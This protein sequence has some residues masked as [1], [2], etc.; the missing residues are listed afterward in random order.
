MTQTFKHEDRQVIRV[1]FGATSRWNRYMEFSDRYPRTP[2]LGAGLGLETGRK[3]EILLSVY[4]FRV[5]GGRIA[6]DLWQH[7]PFRHR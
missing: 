3:A 6:E 1:N 5:A 4:Q 7:P 2:D